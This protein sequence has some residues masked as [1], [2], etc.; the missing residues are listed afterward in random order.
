MVINLEPNNLMIE[1]EPVEFDPF[2][3]N[4]GSVFE[5]GRPGNSDC[6]FAVEY[7][8]YSG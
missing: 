3:F 7:E 1:V 2:C 5:Y 4:G 8:N 6:P